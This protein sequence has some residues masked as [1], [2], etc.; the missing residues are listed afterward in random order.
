[1]ENATC[2]KSL[3]RREHDGSQRRGQ[4]DCDS[5]EQPL[6]TSRPRGSTRSENAHDI[7]MIIVFDVTDE[8][9]SNNMKGRMGEIDKHVSDGYQQAPH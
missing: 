6:F 4:Q 8:E 5:A 2:V 1:M 7:I 3:K 9:S